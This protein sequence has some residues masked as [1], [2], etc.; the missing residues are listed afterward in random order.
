M[1]REGRARE[2]NCASRPVGRVKRIRS[3]LRD[4]PVARAE[5]LCGVGCACNKV[6]EFIIRPEGDATK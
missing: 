5:E 1:S 2:I 3:K 4:V 6:R